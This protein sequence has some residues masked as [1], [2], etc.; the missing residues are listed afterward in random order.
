MIVRFTVSVPCVLLL[1]VDGLSVLH[2]MRNIRMG[3]LPFRACFCSDVFDHGVS[4][5]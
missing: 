3:F 2:S 1:A 4:F 5:V